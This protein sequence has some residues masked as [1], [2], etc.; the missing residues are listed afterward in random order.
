MKS[1]E[2]ERR[3][4]KNKKIIDIKREDDKMIYSVK[5]KVGE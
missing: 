5:N 3:K 2:R 4:I 1:K